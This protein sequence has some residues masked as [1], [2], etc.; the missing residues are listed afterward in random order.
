MRAVVDTN[1]ALKLPSRSTEG[2]LSQ[3]PS[4]I[5]LAPYVLAEVL[6]RGNPEPTLARLREFDVRYGLEPVEVLETVAKSTETEIVTFEPFAVPGSPSY[7]ALKAA[8]YEPST[9]HVEWAREVKSRN[10]NFCSLMFERA[11]F[12][13]KKLREWDLHKE[14]FSD[15]SEVLTKLTFPLSLVVSSISN[16]PLRKTV[17]SD[18]GLLYYAVMRNQYLARF[19]KTILYYVLSFSRAWRDQNHNFDPSVKRDDWTDLTLPLYAANGDIIMTADR[20]LR[21]AIKVIEPTC[22]ISGTS[23]DKM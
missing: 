15:L 14:K 7:E 19:F 12:F 1:Q 20:K 8:L 5:A 16:D 13:R 6:H 22:A 21:N 4:E 9:C 11:K 2:D 18:E 17:V 23:V 10:R 3:A